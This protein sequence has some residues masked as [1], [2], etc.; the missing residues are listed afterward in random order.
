M[1]NSGAWLAAGV[2]ACAAA[3]GAANVTSPA[4][5]AQSPLVSLV[6]EGSAAGFTLEL[7]RTAGTAPLVVTALTVSVDGER[8]PATRNADGSWS[9]AWPRAGAHRPGHLEVVAAHDGIR[10]LL[11]GT[12]PA[13]AIAGG[14]ASGTRGASGTGGA[15]STGVA[16]LWRDHK[17]LAW[18]VLNI[19]VVLIAAIALSR[20]M[21]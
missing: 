16:G 13:S 5:V 10:E 17:Q 4:P 3:A 6:A 8:L 7:R 19:G 15:G 12:L 20:R 21:S 2:L 18:W 1:S 11:S 14:G 9:V